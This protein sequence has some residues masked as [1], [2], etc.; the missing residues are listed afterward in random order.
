[1][2]LDMIV[3]IVI[4]HLYIPEKWRKNN[5]NTILVEKF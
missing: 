4:D 5:K 1:M 2:P 3:T